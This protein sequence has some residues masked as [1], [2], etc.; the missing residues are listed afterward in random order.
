MQLID[1]SDS[2][3]ELSRDDVFQVLSN[4]RRRYALHYLKQEGDLTSIGELAENIAAW[5]NGTSVGEVTSSERKR[6]YISL[7]QLHLPRMEEVGLVE[8]NRSRGVVEPLPRMFDVD[9]YLEV[10]PDNEIPWSNFYLGLAVTNL[11]FLGAGLLNVFPFSLVPGLLWG[12]VV[13]VMFGVSALLDYRSGRKTRL[14]SEYP[15]PDT[16]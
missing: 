2:V 3:S 6:V 10:V 14:G 7:L 11:G 13:A 1:R 12:L 4:R 9:V 16:V 5:E 15:P 8:F